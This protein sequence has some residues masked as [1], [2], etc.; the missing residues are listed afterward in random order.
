M[1]IINV[2]RAFPVRMCCVV[3]GTM[4][5]WSP[6]HGLSGGVDRR[7]AGTI[8]CVISLDPNGNADT[9]TLNSDDRRMQQ[10]INTA[11]TDG[12]KG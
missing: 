1:L 12:R 7:A 9:E 4:P 10:Y 3:D 2:K 6:I 5:K 11:S 8:D